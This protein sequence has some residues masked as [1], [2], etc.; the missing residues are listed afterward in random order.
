MKSSREID[1]LRLLACALLLL[2]NWPL[3]ASAESCPP[4]QESGG[5]SLW[6][7]LAEADD[8]EEAIAGCWP[9]QD[10]ES[11]VTAKIAQATLHLQRGAPGRAFEAAQAAVDLSGSDSR[12]LQIR[13]DALFYLGSHMAAAR[14]FERALDIALADGAPD[15][16]RLAA[17]NK[18][19]GT[20]LREIGDYEGSLGHLDQAKLLAREHY[21]FDI[22]GS[23]LGNLGS[24][25]RRLGAVHLAADTYLE[26]RRLAVATGDSALELDALARLGELYLDAGSP[27]RALDVL[28]EALTLLP[29]STDQESAWLLEILGDAKLAA[30]DAQGSCELFA[31]TLEQHRLDA[32]PFRLVMSLIGRGHCLEWLDPTAAEQTYLEAVEVSKASQEESWSA[33][34]G[35]GRLHLRVGELDSAIEA[36]ERSLDLALGL[37]EAST[38]GTSRNDRQR[39]HKR[40]RPI[41]DGYLEALWQRSQPGDL[42]RAFELSERAKLGER[43]ERWWHSR[44][45]GSRLD[46]RMV[47]IELEMARLSSRLLEGDTVADV[48][49]KETLS[50]LERLEV[51]LRAREDRLW[52]PNLPLAPPTLEELEAAMPERSRLLSFH[53][54]SDA[55]FI[56]DLSKPKRGFFRV[57]VPAEE[58]ELSIE[59]LL[60]LIQRRDDLWRAAAQRL[61]QRLIEPW[62]SEGSQERLLVAAEGPLNGWPLA[63]SPAPTGEYEGK[64]SDQP[65][66]TWMHDVAIE[67]VLSAT[68]A[69]KQWTADRK[70]SPGGG[71]LLLIS[72]PLSDQGTSS[73][74]QRSLS[75]Y[76]QAG[77]MAPLPESQREIETARRF[78]LEQPTLLVGAQATEERVKGALSQPH[79]LVHIAAH[80]IWSPKHPARSALVLAASQDQ[81]G[82]F[83]A[84][85]ILR[86]PTTAE[87]VILSACQTARGGGDG[88]IQHLADA[89][90]IAGARSVV[91]SLWP[92]DDGKTAEL[93]SMFYRRLA[94]GE[95]KAEALRQTQLHF[96]ESWAP[97]HYAA[98]IL[99]GD[100]SGGVQLKALGRSR[101]WL[102]LSGLV[103]VL[104]VLWFVFRVPIGAKD[105]TD[106]RD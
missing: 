29:R 4:V 95:S 9:D 91:G 38:S 25:Y 84:R 47:A 3:T 100:G 65:P 57:D 39:I 101:L 23:V 2:L 5:D 40:V 35:L 20:A 14:D 16:R 21:D 43:A 45:G 81:D 58:L 87:L 11:I 22:L 18:D 102:S 12:A 26:Q 8:A 82:L 55:V 51:E 56:F 31:T 52:N 1:R 76:E 94:S 86:Q 27:G 62:W 34:A 83:Q 10:D 69:Y 44:Q 71:R 41:F 37:D 32:P 103:G 74:R 50:Q 19:L 85:E 46:E 73:A 59:N 92:V 15:P 88:S 53:L 97:K 54:T 30:D 72:Q 93:M 104:L 24:A 70:P 68:T 48:P 67:S 42:E 17:L 66:R 106:A 105:T 79:E 98:F 96:A 89:F 28:Q 80:A 90:F 36:F 49:R 60:E 33:W 99:I 6:T 61:T 63:L 78:S 13:G 64:E 7:W 77:P 75:L